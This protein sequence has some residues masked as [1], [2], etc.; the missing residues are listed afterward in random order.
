MAKQTYVYM[1]API[2]ILLGNNRD[3]ECRNLPA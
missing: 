2:N 3:E 1:S